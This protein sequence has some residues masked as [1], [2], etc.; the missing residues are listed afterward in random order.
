MDRRTDGQP[1]QARRGS[2]VQCVAGQDRE[3]Q[4][5]KKGRQS[6]EGGEEGSREINM[7]SRSR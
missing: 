3:R 2:A 1:V 6:C 7:W 4:G 5:R